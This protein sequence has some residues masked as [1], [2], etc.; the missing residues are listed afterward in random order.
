LGIWVLM[1]A[2]ELAAQH[3]QAAEIVE[4]HH[5]GKKDAPSGTAI[6]T[7]ELL[8]RAWGR[9][10][11]AGIPIHSVRLPGLYSNQEVLFGGTGETLSL[12]HE[13]YDIACFAPGI[14]AALRYAPHADGVAR[15]IGPAFE[16]ASAHA[17]D[18]R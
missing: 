3:F 5:A 11:T 6:A 13:T 1:R 12:R 7:A 18:V 16:H 15:G 2:A 17:R 4:L 14:L 8:A 9:A 10:D